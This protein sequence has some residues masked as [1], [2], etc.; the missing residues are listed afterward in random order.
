MNPELSFAR[1]LSKTARRAVGS[2]P[3]LPAK[4]KKQLL[5]RGDDCPGAVFVLAGNL[6]VYYL[7]RGGREATLYRVE[8]PDGCVLALTATFRSEPY[9][10]WVQAGPNGARYVV[11]PRE[12]FRSLFESE[13]AF[14]DYVF[15]ALSARVFELMTSLEETASLEVEVRIARYLLRHAGHAGVTRQSQAAIANEVGSVREVV[16]RCLREWVKRGWVH[17]GRGFVQILDR[18]ALWRLA[19]EKEPTQ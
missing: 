2:L 6:R 3:I 14:R 10:A 17:N 13:P 9:P 4:A 18:S 11:M 1:G 16:F 8:P 7:T 12:L 5:R 19:F 15:G